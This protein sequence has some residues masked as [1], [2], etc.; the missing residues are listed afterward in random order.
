[1][2]KKLELSKYIACICEGGAEKAVMDILLENKLLIFSKENLIEG[3]F[4]KCRGAQS[5]QE[6]YLRKKFNGKISIIRIL[7]SRNENFKI[8]KVYEDKIDVINIVTAPEIEMLIIHSE[9]MYEKYKSSGKKPCEFCMQDLRK[10]R[11]RKKYDDVIRYFDTPDKLVNA[12]KADHQKQ[13]DKSE[14]S[15]LN[16]LKE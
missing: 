3:R 10:L 9:G 16:L 2:R 4:I 1:M 5:F 13:Q 12:I 14:Y 6:Q 15:L 11:Y 8:S 7:D